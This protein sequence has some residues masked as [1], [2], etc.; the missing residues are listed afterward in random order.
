LFNFIYIFIL[1]RESVA[2]IGNWADA[3]DQ[4]NIRLAAAAG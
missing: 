3:V 4:E 1:L 2:S